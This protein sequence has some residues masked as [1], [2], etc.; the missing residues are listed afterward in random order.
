MSLADAMIDTDLFEDRENDTRGTHF[1][2]E[3]RLENAANE[4]DLDDLFGDEDEEADGPQRQRYECL[5]SRNYSCNTYLLCNTEAA[6]LHQLDAK[7]LR[8]YRLGSYS[9]GKIWN[10]RRVKTR[11]RTLSS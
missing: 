8:P 6:P 4:E 2:T 5:K 9:T 3:P 7:V 11:R 10:T 1:E